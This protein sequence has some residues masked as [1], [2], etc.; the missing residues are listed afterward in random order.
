MIR[1]TGR[2]RRRA[3]VSQEISLTPLIDTA[4]T[5]LIIFMVTT[6][7]MHN[8][9]KITL[10]QAKKNDEMEPAKELIVYVDEKGDLYLHKNK[11]NLASLMT[12]IQSIVGKKRDQIVFIKADKSVSY[13]NVISIVDNLQTIDGVQHVA[14]ATTKVA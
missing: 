5:L 1:S 8:A 2:R 3:L 11:F 13:G 14:L 4:L 12:E 10:P 7:M 9:I 6:P